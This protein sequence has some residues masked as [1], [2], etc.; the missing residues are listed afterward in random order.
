MAA[1]GVRAALYQ[2]GLVGGAVAPAAAA[3]HNNMHH[4]CNGSTSTIH[5]YN[6]ACCQRP[7]LTGSVSFDS[8][9][10]V[11]GGGGR[12]TSPSFSTAASDAPEG[13]TAD[14]E[15]LLSNNRKWVASM[16]QADPE[17]FTRLGKGQSPK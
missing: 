6:C 8:K 12:E 10:S 15:H 11:G 17:F 5:G 4:R 14:I 1:T 3:A 7:K 2:R 9:L 16:N 13:P